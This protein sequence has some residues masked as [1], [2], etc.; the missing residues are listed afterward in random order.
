M[1]AGGRTRR[2]ASKP[3]TPQPVLRCAVTLSLERSTA[4][5]EA[6]RTVDRLPLRLPP[7]LLLQAKHGYLS[8]GRRIALEVLPASLKTSAAGPLPSTPAAP[9]L[10]ARPAP[11]PPPPRPAP[12]KHNRFFLP[13]Q[14]RFFCFCSAP[15]S[16]LQQL[17]Q[18]VPRLKH[19]SAGFPV[20]LAAQSMFASDVKSRSTSVAKAVAYLLGRVPAGGWVL[21]VLETP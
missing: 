4:Q 10:A 14:A 16:A 2:R 5:H 19:F 13:P 9:P 11:R 8:V 20:P 7:P 6:A 21:N 3:A 15:Y 18:P 12:P 17:N 1:P